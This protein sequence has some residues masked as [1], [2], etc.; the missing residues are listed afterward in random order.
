MFEGGEKELSAKLKQA[1]VEMNDGVL[2]WSKSDDPED[3]EAELRPFQR[4]PWAFM[5]EGS[6]PCCER[7]L[8]SAGIVPIAKN[9][10]EALC[11]GMLTEAMRCTTLMRHDG[12]LSVGE[13]K[14]GKYSACTLLLTADGAEPR[15][16]LERYF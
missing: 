12:N 16:F 7:L 15:L 13:I 11:P 2:R 1:A 5:L 10:V 4:T 9:V 6:G 14:V 3:G 8:E